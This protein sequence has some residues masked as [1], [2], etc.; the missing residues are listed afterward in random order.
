MKTI[1]D[2]KQAVSTKNL[3]AFQHRLNEFLREYQMIRPALMLDLEPHA[4]QR[5]ESHVQFLKRH[6]TEI[7]DNQKQLKHL[8]VMEKDFND[9]Y[10]RIQHDSADP[11]LLWVMLT[12]GGMIVVSLSYAGWKKYKGEKKKNKVEQRNNS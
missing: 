1:S 3:Q 2:M 6:R 9:M 11:S 4:F 5:V 10:D 7:N 12:I 8:E